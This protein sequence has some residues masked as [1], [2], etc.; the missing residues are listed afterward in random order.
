MNAAANDIAEM[1]NAWN[2]IQA[3]ARKQFPKASDEE[4]YQ[5]A[6]GAMLHTLRA[7]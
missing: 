7:A 5:I 3:A 4:I 1:M 6:K 2:K